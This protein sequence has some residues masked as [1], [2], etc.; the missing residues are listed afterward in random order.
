MSKLL[1]EAVDD[2][3]AY[4]RVAFSP[5]T[6][7]A[8]DQGMRKFL[9]VIGN[10]QVRS[11]GPEHGER[12]QSWL[13]SRGY[14]PNSV[15]NYMSVLAT[16]STWATARRY[17]PPSAGLTATVRV[18]ATPA[19]PRLRI[20]AR[21]MG[22]VLD[23]CPRPD[24]RMMV[25]LGFYLFLRAS[26]MT[27]LKVGDVDLASGEVQVY[28]QKGKRYD[29]MPI[30]WELDQELRSWLTIYATDVE[31]NL[32][33]GDYL[34]PSHRPTGWWD[35]DRTTRCWRPS[36]PMCQP[37]RHIHAVLQACGYETR[38]QDGS[39]KR[40]GMHTLRRSGARAYYDEMIATGSVRDDVLP[41]VMAMLHHRSVAVT[42]HY[43]GLEAD[44]EKRD[45]RLKGKRMFSS[46]DANVIQMAK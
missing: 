25:A 28:V 26:E 5:N 44:R 22:R 11:L 27:N 39:S 43:L 21:E 15:N 31:R 4:R 23:A 3:V 46:H 18:I 29:R 34:V 24:I 35:A 13:I 41:Q 30:C 19:P 9:L 42:E 33:P 8:A 10:V 36:K 2:F 6:A 14:K 38:N 37:T 1:S 45:L 32:L 16:F 40:E 20:P 17:L 12:F 7:K